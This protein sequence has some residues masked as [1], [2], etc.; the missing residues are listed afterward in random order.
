MRRSGKSASL[1][2]DGARGLRAALVTAS[3]MLALLSAG[4]SGRQDNPDPA[5]LGPIK[6]SP[7]ETRGAEVARKE[8]PPPTVKLRRAKDGSYSWE[9]TG[10]DVREVMRAD[11]ALRKGLAR[12][13][14]KPSDGRSAGGSGRE[15][16]E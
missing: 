9:L 8:E 14:K 16:E 7:S 15:G 4:C 12:F 1:P 5:T 11:R 10:K 2:L 6:A 13:E 3:L